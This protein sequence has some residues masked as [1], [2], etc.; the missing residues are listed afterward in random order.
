MLGAAHRI[1]IAQCAT[2]SFDGS[3]SYAALGGRQTGAPAVAVG[4]FDRDGRLDLAAASPE[5]NGVS[6]FLNRTR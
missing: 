4:D 5:N 6:V 1:A 2:A 3:R